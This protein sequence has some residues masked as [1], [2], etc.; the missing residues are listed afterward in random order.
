[1]PIEDAIKELATKVT[2]HG[3]ALLT[4]EATKTAVVL[5]FIARV[6][7]YDV[8]DPSEVLPE[9]TSDIG[10]K[11]GEKV[12]F[13]I[14]RGGDVQMLIECKPIGAPLDINHASQ[15]FRYFH[16]TNARIG[17]LTNGQY[18]HFFT[19]LDQP[20]KM[21]QHPFLRLNLLDVDPYALP[22]LQKMT[23]STFDLDSVLSAAEELKYVSGVKQAIDQLFASPTEEFVRLLAAKVYDRPLT[24]KMRE[25]FT[26]VTVKASKQWITEQVNTRLKTALQGQGVSMPAPA[27]T[28]DPVEDSEG[29]EGPKDI[30]TTFEEIEGFNIVRAIAVSDVPVER[31]AARD[32]KSYFGIL[33]DDNNRK[34]ICRL[35]FNRKQKF[36][37][38][39]GEDK[40]ETRIPIDKISDIYHHADAIREAVRRFA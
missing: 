11:K 36:I 5:P 14:L 1:M 33:L 38:I 18:W 34:P 3:R 15:L 8:F 4:E 40:S 25:F 24:A 20:N 23:K 6:L 37:G 7:G 9:F 32:T 19:D 35:H 28:S 17:V 30:E 29:D 16:V 2:D 12:D 10:T 22:E 21:D 39:V 26:G 27:A 13:A 31:V